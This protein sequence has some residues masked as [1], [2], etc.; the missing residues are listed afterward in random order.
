MVTGL[1]EQNF[2]SLSG[3]VTI[4]SPLARATSTLPSWRGQP[5]VPAAAGHSHRVVLSPPG[6]RPLAD[7]AF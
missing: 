2:S 3:G 7:Q 5:T 4:G 6:P 1:P